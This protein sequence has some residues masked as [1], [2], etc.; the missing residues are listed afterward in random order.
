MTTHYL[1][2]NPAKSQVRICHVL[3]GLTDG[4]IACELRLAS[5]DSLP[6]YT[7]LS[8]VWGKHSDKAEIILNYRPFEVTSNL[9]IVLQQLQQNRYGEPIWIDA[10]CTNQTDEEEKSHQV[11]LMGR[12]YRQAEEVLVWLRPVTVVSGHGEDGEVV[13]EPIVS[14]TMLERRC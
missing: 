4:N 2:L 9:Y 8:Y 10:M 1:P 14:N 11:A 3:P 12:I 5:L 7:C 6:R 13:P